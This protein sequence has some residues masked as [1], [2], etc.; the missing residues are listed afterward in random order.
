MAARYHKAEDAAAAETITS[1][2]YIGHWYTYMN[3]TI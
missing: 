3:D 2:N 1:A